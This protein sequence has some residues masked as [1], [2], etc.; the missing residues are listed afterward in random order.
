[1]EKAMEML[2]HGRKKTYEVA[3]AVGYHDPN[4]F[5]TVFKKQVGCSPTEYRDRY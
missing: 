3:S 2:K 1:M 5:S 4:Y